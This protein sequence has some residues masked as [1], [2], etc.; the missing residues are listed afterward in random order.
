MIA[1]CSDDAV[2]VDRHRARPLRRHRDRDER[3]RRRGTASDDTAR[4][5]AEIALPPV[6]RSLLR[7]TT[8]GSSCTPTGSLS[9]STKAPSIVN[10]ATFGPD[11]PRSIVRTCSVNASLSRLACA[12][13]RGRR[14]RRPAAR[15]RGSG[16]GCCA[17]CRR[18]SARTRSAR[19]T[20]PASRSC[21]CDELVRRRLD[22]V[23]APH[24]HRDRAD[25][26]LGDPADVVLVEP[27]RDPR[28]FAQITAVDAFVASS[29]HDPS[30]PAPRTPARAW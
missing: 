5:A 26:A 24:D 23:P 11:V 19:T 10:S 25:L 1:S 30:T 14:S 28:R 2:G 8:V 21:M 3:V 13:G 6:V 18:R 12:S 29:R 16:R 7:A 22:A 27:R 9:P 20:T 17:C 15:A 4:C